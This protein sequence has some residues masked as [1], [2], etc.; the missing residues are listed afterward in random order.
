MF[1]LVL[2]ALSVMFSIMVHPTEFDLCVR[3]LGLVSNSVFSSI[4]KCRLPILEFCLNKL[5]VLNFLKMSF[6]D[7]LLENRRDDLKLTP[8]VSLNFLGG[9][10]IFR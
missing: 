8:V 1:I 5:N 4:L 7:D 10:D 9:V 6:S 3:H 2:K